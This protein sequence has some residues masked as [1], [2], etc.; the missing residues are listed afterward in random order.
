MKSFLDY[1]IK[2]ESRST[3]HGFYMS[4]S[5]RYQSSQGFFR[6]ARQSVLRRV[7]VVSKPFRTSRT[8]AART[9]FRSVGPLLEIHPYD[10]KIRFNGTFNR[11]S[12]YKGP[13]SPE[14]DKAW[15]DL[16]PS[17]H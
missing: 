15:D 1:R 10:R 6:D 3:G 12:P 9:N 17:K 5:F 4:C 7:A 14:V 2:G 13:P 8:T 16:L 11:D